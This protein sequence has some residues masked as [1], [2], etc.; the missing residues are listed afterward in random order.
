MTKS[1]PPH[2]NTESC[3]SARAFLIFKDRN[4]S[5]SADWV[6]GVREVVPRYECSSSW[7]A[8]IHCSD[9]NMFLHPDS[10]PGP[11]VHFWR[12][13]TPGQML[14]TRVQV[15][16]ITRESRS[17]RGDFMYS[18]SRRITRVLPNPG[19]IQHWFLRGTE[20]R[21]TTALDYIYGTTQA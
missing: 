17:I 6:T 1:K 5:R 2:D 3:C 19:H 20:G 15:E 12:G 4:S 8:I 11:A 13:D 7:I 14:L 10:N 16:S 18:L 9:A 21:T